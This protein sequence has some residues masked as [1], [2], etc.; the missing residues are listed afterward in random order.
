MEQRIKKIEERLDRI[1]QDRDGT[2][3]NEKLLLKLAKYHR[4]GLQEIKAKVEQL[5]LAQGDTNERLDQ[6]ERSLERH[7]RRLEGIKE[8]LGKLEAR[9]GKLEDGMS[10]MESAQVEQGQK[11]D[12]IVKLLQPKLE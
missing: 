7:D 11:L 2:V 5:E 4:A 9:M 12:L 8:D 1:E 6:I 10:R 3:E